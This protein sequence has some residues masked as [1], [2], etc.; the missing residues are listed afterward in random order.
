VCVPN[1]PECAAAAVVTAAS[2][3]PIGT[4]VASPAART[5]PSST[6]GHP[7]TERLIDAHAKVFSALRHLGYREGE[8]KTVLVELRGD[9]GLADA[10]VERLL[11]EA[12]CR[13]KPIPR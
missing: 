10:S 6:S 7:P 12:L 9:V 5:P 13:I 11:R 3:E 8:V 4:A 2:A 1:P